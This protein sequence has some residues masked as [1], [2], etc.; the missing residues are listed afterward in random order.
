MYWAALNLSI[1]SLMCGR[2]NGLG[3]VTL[4]NRQSKNSHLDPSFF[5]TRIAGNAQGDCDG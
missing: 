1:R 2:G 3:V 5:A 4:F